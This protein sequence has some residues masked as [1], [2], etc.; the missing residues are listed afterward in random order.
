MSV[1]GRR[2][3]RLR[4]GFTLVE[5]LVVIA[6]IGVLLALLLPAVQAAREA[7]RSL[8]CKNNL[9]QL[10]LA[11]HN[12]VS[13]HAGVFPPGVIYNGDGSRAFWFGWNASGS[14]AID[15][16]RG[17]LPPYYESNRR[18]TLCPDLDVTRVEMS[19]QGGTG[20]YGYNYNFLSPVPWT[21]DPVTGV[22]TSTWHPVR[23]DD[24]KTTTRTIAFADS[25]ATKPGQMPATVAETIF[26]ES[27]L[28][29]PPVPPFGDNYPTIHFRH[30]GKTA[31]VL[32]VDG[33]V[34]TW[35]QP[36]R[37]PA[38]IW[39][40]PTVVQAR[41]KMLLYDIGADNELWDLE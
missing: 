25:L 39:D 11:L 7:A 4:T 6:I 41:D 20:G 32:F 36:A 35:G 12:Y 33:H 14:D 27:P 16:S 3:A 24:V 17:Q 34:E 19:Y 23:I 9:K 1:D 30:G 37:N 22:W 31:N 38:S 21:P 10:G 5:L 2:D 15:L 8:Q 18:V 29:E 26:V 28:I 13:V 40:P